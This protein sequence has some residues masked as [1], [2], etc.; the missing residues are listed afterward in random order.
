MNSSEHFDRQLL[1]RRLRALLIV[2]S[3]L[4][5]GF[6]VFPMLGLMA[7][8]WVRWLILALW[9]LVGALLGLLIARLLK[10]LERLNQ[11]GSRG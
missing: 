1:Q 9:V 11:D 10:T 5:P 2:G 6:C 8:G 3:F 4:L 7:S